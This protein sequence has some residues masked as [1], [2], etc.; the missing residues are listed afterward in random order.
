MATTGG[1]VLRCREGEHTW[2]DR[3]A[4]CTTCNMLMW[5][6]ERFALLEAAV[7]A[8]RECVT[9]WREQASAEEHCQRSGGNPKGAFAYR[10]CAD[11]LEQSLD[12]AIW[13][14]A[15]NERKENDN[16]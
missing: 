10:H 16:E 13:F 9:D 5:A 3:W 1:T 8:A 12:Q 4:F 7:K 11:D 15:V 6:P 2:H 14:R